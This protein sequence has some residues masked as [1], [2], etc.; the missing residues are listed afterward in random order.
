[1]QTYLMVTSPSED[2]G[3][4]TLRSITQVSRTVGH[5]IRLESEI[6]ACRQDLDD[7]GMVRR[8]RG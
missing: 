3:A 8:R 6:Q 2:L 5:G 7:D 1:M 4:M